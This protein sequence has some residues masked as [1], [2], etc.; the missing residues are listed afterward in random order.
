MKLSIQYLQKAIESGSPNIKELS[1]KMAITLIE[2]ID[3]LTKIAA[4]FGF[5]NIGNT[6][7][8]RFRLMK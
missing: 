2:Q 3:Q 4:I 1:Q 7:N 8:E 5:A 6:K